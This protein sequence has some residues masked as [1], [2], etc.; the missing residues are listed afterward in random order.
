MLMKSVKI[1]NFRGYGE[2]PQCE[3]GFFCFDQ[4]DKDFVL[5]S[6]FNGFGKTSFYEAVEWCLSDTV[7]RLEKLKDVYNI[8]DLRKGKYLKFQKANGQST[9][10]REIVVEIQFI[11]PASQQVTTITRRTNSNMLGVG[12][13]TSIL[14]MQQGEEPI[15]EVNLREI[16]RVLF[17]KNNITMQETEV[18]EINRFLFSN[19]MTQDNLHDFLHSN[20]LKE[21]Q[22]LF[23]RLMSR[24]EGQKI[25]ERLKGITLNSFTNKLNSVNAEIELK[26]ATINRVSEKVQVADTQLYFDKLN[27]D[28]QDVHKSLLGF[29]ES[30]LPLPITMGNYK[31]FL[32]KLEELQNATLHRNIEIGNE[33]DDL[34]FHRIKTTELTQIKQVVDLLQKEEAV[35]RLISRNLASLNSLIAINLVKLEEVEQQ[36]QQVDIK[37]EQYQHV[38]AA[39]RLVQQALSNKQESFKLQLEPFIQQILIHEQSGL[40]LPLIHQLYKRDEELRQNADQL[41]QQI[42]IIDKQLKQ[43][44]TLSKHY[45]DLLQTVSTY[46]TNQE[47]IDQ[48]PVC[49]NTTVQG[50]HITKDNLLRL[51]DVTIAQGSTAS[52]SMIQE[53]RAL[54][55][56]LKTTHQQIEEL[57]RKPILDYVHAQ[58]DKF[59]QL[60]STAK[61]EVLQFGGQMEELSKELRI[62]KLERQQFEVDIKHL[63]V[64]SDFTEATILE[65]RRTIQS[66]IQP[67]R[68]RLPE[69]LRYTQLTELRLYRQSIE[70]GL[71]KH[72]SEQEAT[73]LI[74]QLQQQYQRGQ[75]IVTKL[76][77]VAGWVLQGDDLQILQ[78][79]HQLEQKLLQ[80][81]EDVQQI[82]GLK[83]DFVQLR[84]NLADQEKVFIQEQLEKHPIITWIYEMINPHPFYKKL[85]IVNEKGGLHF[86]SEGKEIHL[87]QIFS[88]SQSNILVLSI[89]LGLGMTQQYSRLGQLFLDD[90]IQSMDDVNILGFIDLLRAILDS[91]S[92]QNNLVVS[93]HDSNFAKL[94][95]IKMRNRPFVEYQIIAYGEEGPLIE[96]NTH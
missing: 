36:L 14:C 89:F 54:Q 94:L 49:H 37:E 58:Q 90:P 45:S 75:E 33:M 38:L 77:Q 96:V 87:D 66:S 40:S 19:I 81:E 3:D 80:L 44:Q 29:L 27:T 53:Q 72:L 24:G 20:D 47:E 51:I 32:E 28:L 31:E 9:D 17:G 22:Q 64:A 74:Q 23:L 55:A 63:G 26:R 82:E 5:I 92:E 78:Q 60:L 59:N 67:A 79:Q 21:R 8:P 95:G 68:S 43:Q 39:G 76:Q 12:E 57:V 6:G 18:P 10:D 1:K 2:N 93:T 42:H 35:D 25:S 91:Q 83:K 13:Y 84:T 34:K 71:T 48:C 62:Q 88:A 41:T 70:E 52:A 73:E 86:K 65:M 15:H 16:D 50:E 46:I 61:T 11:E 7:K 85:E 69:V 4:L 30:G 56:N